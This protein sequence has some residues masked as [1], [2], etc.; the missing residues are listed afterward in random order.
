MT[1]VLLSWGLTLSLKELE[2]LTLKVDNGKFVIPEINIWVK[3]DR[4]WR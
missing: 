2:G 4:Y 1:E 3:G